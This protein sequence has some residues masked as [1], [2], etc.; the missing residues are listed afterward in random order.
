MSSSIIDAAQQ[1][2]SQAANVGELIH[3]DVNEPNTCLLHRLKGACY[4]SL[5]RQ[6]CHLL[7]VIK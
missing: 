4:Y 5:Y 6:S 1:Q 2:K 3:P 7:V